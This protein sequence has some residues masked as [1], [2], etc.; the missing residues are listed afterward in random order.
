MKED[1]H[2]RGLREADQDLVHGLLQPIRDEERDREQ[3]VEGSRFDNER[4]EGEVLLRVV[5]REERD[6][7][8]AEGEEARDDERGEDDVHPQ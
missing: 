8:V 4:C 6:V 3:R 7:G 2:L 1:T 5:G